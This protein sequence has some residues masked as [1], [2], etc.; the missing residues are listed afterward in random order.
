MH[1]AGQVTPDV[2]AAFQ[3]PEDPAD[4]FRDIAAEN[5]KSAFLPSPTKE[6]E[7]KESQPDN[8]PLQKHTSDAMPQTATP[9]GTM[10]A[11]TEDGD[12]EQT[13]EVEGR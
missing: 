8:G 6:D 1:V 9:P 4:F 12:G 3:K 11:S 7:D 5:P 10:D 13:F 2:A